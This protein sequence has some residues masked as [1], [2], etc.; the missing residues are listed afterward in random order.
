VDTYSGVLFASAHT[1]EATKPALGHLLGA[2]ANFG[3]PKSIK[4]DNSPAYTSTKFQEFCKLWDITHNTGIPY[5]PQGQAIV[6][7]KHQK[8][9]NKIFKIRK[10]VHLQV[11][12]Y[13]ITSHPIN[14]QFFLTL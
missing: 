5:N 7:Q 1:G 10:R 4:T 2:F 13:P 6:E 3:I 14:F 8:I 12:T 11:S 9:K